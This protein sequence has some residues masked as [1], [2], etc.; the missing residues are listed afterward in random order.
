MF[1]KGRFAGSVVSFCPPLVSVRPGG[2]TVGDLVNQVHF[3]VW[4]RSV[5][6]MSGE[7]ERDSSTWFCRWRR[8]LEGTDWDAEGRR[9]GAGSEPGPS[10]LRFRD[11]ISS[12]GWSTLTRGR[13]HLKPR[14]L[15]FRII[16]P[17]FASGYRPHNRSPSTFHMLRP[18]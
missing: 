18:G 10:R 11:I 4:K 5:I 9:E 15:S 14:I 8:L 17:S 1:F 12:V 16:S 3:W 2:M 7:P 6:F 13:P